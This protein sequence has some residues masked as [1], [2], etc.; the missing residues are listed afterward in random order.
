MRGKFDETI[1]PVSSGNFNFTP[2]QQAQFNRT[3]SFL[4]QQSVPVDTTS[5]IKPSDLGNTSTI[6]TRTNPPTNRN[7]N[8]L[9]GI[10]GPA[11]EQ[12]QA[13]Y[14]A[15]QKNFQTTPKSTAQTYADKY[16]GLTEQ[17]ASMGQDKLDLQDK[18]DIERK[19]KAANEINSRM[20]TT[21]RA[22][23]KQLREIEKNAQGALSGGVNIELQ[24]VSKMRDE[25]LADLAI[26]KSVALGDLETA[27]KIVET[28]L[29]AK[30]EP[31]QQQLENYKTLIDINNNNMTEREKFEAQQNYQN[32]KDTINYYQSLQSAA[33]NDANQ[34]GQS[35]VASEILRLDPSAP[36]FQ[37]KLANLQA[38]IVKTSSGQF[39]GLSSG[40]ASM[41]NTIAQSYRK[42]PLIAASD[43]VQVL[44]N[45]IADAKNNPKDGAKQ[46]SLVYAY[47]QAL[48]TYQSAVREGELS[49][50]SSIDSRIGQL[51]NSVQKITD[52]QIV[53]PEVVNQIAGAAESIVNTIKD[54][55]RNK[56]KDFASQANVVGLGEVWGKYT[57]GFTPSYGNNEDP[58][59]IL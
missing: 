4:N 45:A 23:D 43:R 3:L 38:K 2:E 47:I 18:Y 39:D 29:A 54:G 24:R 20:I 53:R 12:A 52:G 14:D 17:Y 22:Y 33:V 48:D 7:G 37:N 15:S 6:N 42:S 11:V 55:A 16:L 49:L 50:V 13:E 28:T 1:K 27:N 25:Q 8:A 46:L 35:G 30:Y 26:Q 34:S 10:V 5:P 21:A 44:E 56:E 51:S 41:L 36:D 32:A 19:T 31:I 9:T 57:S 59:G 58:M 40:Q